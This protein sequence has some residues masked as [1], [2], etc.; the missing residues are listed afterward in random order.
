MSLRNWANSL[1]QKTRT[2][3]IKLVYIPLL[4]SVIITLCV[5]GLT[6]VLFELFRDK[7]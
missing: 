3:C 6:L 2:C 1:W 7:Q 5:M 4:L